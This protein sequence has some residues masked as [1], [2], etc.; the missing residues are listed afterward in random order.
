MA[1]LYPSFFT[2]PVARLDQ[3]LAAHRE[4]RLNEAEIH[5]RA[6]L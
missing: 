4:G 3:G 2:A 1:S 6:V 5:Y